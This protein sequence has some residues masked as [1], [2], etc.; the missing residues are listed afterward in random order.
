MRSIQQANQG[1]APIGIKQIDTQIQKVKSEL[2]IEQSQ[3]LERSMREA[4]INKDTNLVL[5]QRLE[6]LQEE[7]EKYKKQTDEILK[8]TEG[9]GIHR[10]SIHS[11]RSQ[12]IDN[13]KLT[14]DQI[15]QR[16]ILALELEMSQK[17]K[18][19][20]AEIE[21]LKMDIKQLTHDLNEAWNENDQKDK[22]I[23]QLQTQN[24]LLLK[25]KQELQKKLMEEKTIQKKQQSPQKIIEP[26]NN[27]INENSALIEGLK[28]Q[29]QELQ[30]EISEYDETINS[31]QQEIS[32]WKN[33]YSQ[34]Q[35]NKDEVDNYY[36]IAY[37]K[38]ESLLELKE[39]M[40]NQRKD[41]QNKINSLEGIIIVLKN[42]LDELENEKKRF[43]DQIDTI[44]KNNQDLRAENLK[45]FEQLASKP[46]EVNLNLQNDL[47]ELC[48]APSNGGEEFIQQF[49][50]LSD[51][52]SN[53]KSKYT[54]ALEQKQTLE[55]ENNRKAKENS[56]LNDAI[57][58][59]ENKVKSQEG[60]IQ[61]WI[62]KYNSKNT[63]LNAILEQEN[64]D[65]LKIEE[66]ELHIKDQEI[67]INDLEI[68]LKYSQKDSTPRNKENNTIKQRELEEKLKQANV[69]INDLKKEIQSLQQQQNNQ[70]EQNDQDLQQMIQDLEEQNEKLKLDN[71]KL[72]S[73]LHD[74]EKQISDQDQIIKQQKQKQEELEQKYKQIP[75][76]NPSESNQEQEALIERLIQNNE[77]LE[78]KNSQLMQELNLIKNKNSKNLRSKFILVGKLMQ[79][80]KLNSDLE[81]K[82]KKQ[83][84]IINEL[85][86][87][88]KNE[89]T[90]KEN[91]SDPIP[92]DNKPQIEQQAENEQDTHQNIKEELV[93][94]KQRNQKLLGKIF[95]ILTKQKQKDAIISQLEERIEKQKA[96][97]QEL[98]ENQ[99]NSEQQPKI[100]EEEQQ[101][102]EVETVHEQQ[103]QIQDNQQEQKNEILKLKT[104]NQKLLSKI[105]R[106]M[107]K[108]KIQEDEVQN[109]NER[110]KKQQAI[111]DAIT[112]EPKEQEE[113]QSEQEQL[114]ID[115]Q[116]N[117]KQI[118]LE[119]EN[120]DV[121]YDQLKIKNQNQRL[122]GKLFRTMFLLNKKN[123]EIESLLQRIQK[124]KAQ[125]EEL[126]NQIHE[127]SINTNQ[128]EE[129]EKEPNYNL[130]NNQAEQ[131]QQE[132]NSNEIEQQNDALRN[133][134]INKM[135]AKLFMIMSKF[136]KQNK[137]IENLNERLSKY[138]A[139]IES[140]SQENQQPQ[141]E[142]INIIDEK[143][144]NDKHSTDQQMELQNVN[145]QENVRLKNQN[146]KLL[147][148]LF[149]V[150]SGFTRKNNQIQLLEQ[151]LTKLQAII[152]TLTQEQAPNQEVQE[153]QEQSNFQNKEN[154]N[155]Q[156]N[157][158]S[159][160]Q[161]I[162]HQNEISIWKQKY[163]K[164]L[165]KLFRILSNQKKKDKELIQ[166]NER[167]N[168]QKAINDEL[169]EEK[170]QDAQIKLEPELNHQEI[171]LQAASEINPEKQPEIFNSNEFLKIKNQN[172]KALSKL[173]RLSFLLQKQN[174][175]NKQLND[176]L[177]KQNAIIEEFSKIQ[178][179]SHQLKLKNGKLLAKLFILTSNL[180]I[181]NKA[182]EELSRKLLQKNAQL[183]QLVESSN[184]EEKNSQMDLL[185]KQ[186][187][188]K[189]D[190]QNQNQNEN[191]KLE[192]QRLEIQNK[193]YLAKIFKLLCQ[194]FQKDRENDQLVRRLSKQKAI[195]QDLIDNQNYYEQQTDDGVENMEPQQVETGSVAQKDLQKL[196]K[197]NEKMLAKQFKLLFT[198]KKLEN[199]LENA[200]Q[201]L[202]KQKEI[203]LQSLKKIDEQDIDLKQLQEQI[204]V[205]KNELQQ[206]KDNLNPS[207][208]QK[209]K[210]DVKTN[211]DYYKNKYNNLL[212]EHLHLLNVGD[213]INEQEKQLRKEFRQQLEEE[214]LK[215][216]D[217]FNNLLNEHLKLQEE[218]EK[219]IDALNSV[220]KN[221]DL[222]VDKNELE[223][224]KNKFNSLLSEHLALEELNDGLN[225]KQDDIKKDHEKQLD[226]EIQK[227]KEKY[228][229]LLN[230]YLLL[231]M[232]RD[233]ILQEQSPKLEN[234]LDLDKDDDV[235]QKQSEI[236]NENKEKEQIHN[237]QNQEQVKSLLDQL[238]WLENQNSQLKQELENMKNLL[239]K[240]AQAEPQ[241]I[242][243]T[244]PTTEPLK[245]EPS[246]EEYYKNKYNNLLEE[247][248]HLLNVGDLINEQEKQ[249]RK[250][251]RQ[252]LEEEKLKAKDLFNNL[253]NEH[254]KLQEE[255]EKA[256]DAL[257]SVNKN[258]DLLVDKNE[259]ETIKNKFN[260]LLSEHL[261]LEE[262]NDGLNKKQ[263]DIKKDHEKQLDEEIQKQKEKYNKLLNQYLLLEMQRDGILQEQS[264]KLENQLDLDKDDDVIQKQSEIA[265]ENKEKEQI[266]NVQNQEQVKQLLDQL[267]WLENQ[268][269]QL[270]QELEAIKLNNNSRQ[271][272]EN[273]ETEE[274][275]PS[276][277][278]SNQEQIDK[279]TED[280]Y[281]NKYNN[282]LEEHLHL[283][284][285]GDLINEQEKQLR[286]EFRQQLE[287]EKLKAKDLFNNL[288]NEHL[289]LQEECERAIDALNSVN[290][291]QDLLVDKNELETIK[292]KFNSLLSEHLA[293]EELNDGLNKKQDDIKK[294]HEKQLDEEIQKQK[295]KYNK[296]LNQYLLL[297]MQRDGI[298]QEQSP[299]L[300]N[301]LDLDKDDDVIQKQSEIA[302]ENKEKDQMHNVQN[303]EQVKQLLDQL[304]QLENQNSQL[305]YELENM[306]N[307]LEKTAQAEPQQIVKTE[308]TIEPLK[309]EP[310]SEEYY[311]N[312]YNNLLE[313]HLHLLNVGDLIN[314][315][316]KQLRKEF[317]QQLEEEKL[318][319]KDLF[320]NLLNEHL[321]L[322]EECERAI[323]ALNSVNKNQ[324][325]LVDKNELET[326]KNKFNSLLSE[327]L[328]LE[329]LNDGLNKKQDDIKKDH[330][331]QL[332]EEIQ[333]QKEKYNKLLNQYLLLEMQR[334]GILQEQSPKLENQL[335][336]DK[337]D[338]VI[339]K[340]SEIA[341]ENKEKEQIHNVQNQEQVKQLLDQLNWLEN[342]NSQLKQELEAIKLNNNSRQLMENIETEEKE[343]S[344]QQSNQEQIDKSTEDYYKN[345]YNNL[346]E[347]HLHLLN[348]G[349]LINEQE[350][351]LRKEFR[352]QLEEEKLKAK[353][354]FNNLLNEHLKLQEECEK[355]IDALNS[356]NK[357]QDLLVDKNELE[358]IKNKFNSLLSE[359]LALEEL[360]DG[361]NKKQDDIKKDHE[362]QLDEEIQKQKEKYNKLLNQYLLLEMQ[363][364]G[365]LQEQSPKL[366]NQ[367]DLDK[368]DDVIQKQ[369]EIA[370]ENKE[371]EQIHNVQNQEQVKQL[372]DQLNWLENQNSQLKQELEAIKLNNNSR[373]L[374]ENIETEEKE[375]SKQQSNQEQI[376]KSTED[377]YKN[378]YN[379]LLEEH[380]HLL[381]VGDLINEQEKQLRKEFRQQ[382]EE[383]KLKAKDLF[384]NLLNEHLKLQEECEKA[385]DALNSVN[386]NQDLLVDKNELETIKNKFNSLL[387][388]H[389][390]LEELNDGLNKKQDD[391][392]KDH[393]K[394]L[395]E[396]IQKQKEK[397]NKLLNQYLLLEM[398]RDGILQEQSPKLENQLD[399]DKDDDVIQKQSEIANENKE[400]EQIHNV[401]NQEQVKQ[402]LDQLN[403]L[404]NQNSQLKQELEAIKLNN[405]SRQL[406]ENIETEEKEPSKQQSNQE[407]IDKSTED[408]YKNKY[409]NLLEE[410]LHLLNVG[411]LI[412]EQE[413]QLRKE[414]RQQL[415]EEKLKAKDLFNNL[416]NEHL[417]LQ[418]EC[419]KAI[420][421]LNSVNKNQDLLVDKN[422][423]ETIKNKFNSLLS[424]HLALEEL[425]D[426]LN[427]KQDDIKKDHEKQLD[428]E[429]QKQKEKYNKLLNQY[430]LLEM[431]RD[432]ILQE[433][434]PKLEN[435]L[436]LD[437]D[438][439]VIQKQSEIA[440]EN[441]EK[442]QIHNQQNQEQVKSLLDQLH[443]LENQNSQLKQELENMKN[444][445]EKTAQA[446]PQQ[447]VKTEPT[448]EPLKIEPSSEEYYKNKY[449]NLLEEHL[450]LL[451]VGD[452]IN[453]Q[454]KQLRKEFRQQL[455]EEK[456]KAKDLFNNLLNEHLKLQE[457]CEKAIDALNSVNKN[458][459]L[460]V[461]KN[462]LETI[463]NK[464]NSLLSEHLALEELNDGLNK[465]QDDIK[466]DHEKQLDEEIQKQKEKYNKLLNQYLLLEMQRDGILQEQSPKLENQLDLDKDDDVVEKKQKQGHNLNNDEQQITLFG[467]QGEEN[468]PQLEEIQNYKQQITELQSQL[469]LL[470]EEK[471]NLQKLNLQLADQLNK[472]QNQSNLKSSETLDKL[473]EK[474]DEQLNST[475]QQS[476][477]RFNKENEIFEK[478]GLELAQQRQELLAAQEQLSKQEI[479]IT[480]FEKDKEL[481][482]NE[483][484]QLKTQVDEL[485]SKLEN[486]EQKLNE[487]TAHFVQTMEQ[488]LKENQD[489]F[490]ENKQLV[491]L[492]Q[493]TQ[494]VIQI[495]KKLQH[496]QELKQS[497]K[498]SQDLCS[499]QENEKEII[500]LKHYIKTLEDN[501][502]QYSDGISV[503]N[504]KL[505][506]LFN[507]NS[508]LQTQIQQLNQQSQMN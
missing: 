67:K 266:H 289:K 131:P 280:Y 207:K 277:Q 253:L 47:I 368:D 250:E 66:L 435:Q 331:K 468:S 19:F 90:E 129:Q 314:E 341:N 360:N 345:K 326:I 117:N 88:Q 498:Q 236:A 492:N 79:I 198:I 208:D 478:Q 130:Q 146:N 388:E 181:Q 107:T 286:K 177:V 503:L 5:S 300:E 508:L 349:D 71:D 438:D 143:L 403:W 148:K 416:L 442:E 3:A 175:E 350:K 153:V 91:S 230:Q 233:G 238:H 231:E 448:T 384:N 39:E 86:E 144:E 480:K 488:L 437:K 42:N 340:Q 454:E 399:L 321:K 213:L 363:R 112:T 364:D 434:S 351:Q 338:D 134:K 406:M 458:Q 119:V 424:E 69:Q 361:L 465:K 135:A 216:K 344:K 270:K 353:D 20:L 89:N 421:A 218:C 372:L 299:K 202:Q 150:M 235:I 188:Q 46:L 190:L 245:I 199:Q 159:Q 365:I 229:K 415:E 26:Q 485:Q 1:Q 127:N 440:N 295:E 274:K 497:R 126:N 358:T 430:L 445:L 336:L 383:E 366:E 294:D 500:Q 425:N 56:L 297:E 167:L 375:P 82:L 268:N 394:Q 431:Q 356:V 370:N 259:L 75:K 77:Q 473:V 57:K 85:L 332:D 329:E 413:K 164:L 50:Q 193:K 49:N 223:T 157:S 417:K 343:P 215:A 315:Q 234:Q 304:N 494:P 98:I 369:S 376:D 220:N 132:F 301:Q 504:R 145:E 339:Q 210:Q 385:I 273:I 463:K 12:K 116:Q 162:K 272:M 80:E 95:R 6:K 436:D 142:N 137:L 84:G 140:Q 476:Q 410:H 461:D 72:L 182:N 278:Q 124:Q 474:K 422:E 225:K 452:L 373:Q 252:Q 254:L 174:K 81:D 433:Q 189:E 264:P 195:V 491:L 263:D 105:L 501:R 479:L 118:N 196:Q 240:T 323:D 316:E 180:N 419:E 205:L 312:K 283:L 73:Q 121:D 178:N 169:M 400:K 408:Y 249:L 37:D 194:M 94:Q 115:D 172:V 200:L 185:Q 265:N 489:D 197:A 447:I 499:T 322:Q 432:G 141:A 405:N 232:Q 397:Y 288:L 475:N 302:N 128:I 48:N 450:H 62:N 214:K 380:L 183:Q 237:Q 467:A 104:Q 21:N 184:E 495:L 4:K 156:P 74:A 149:R 52:F 201:R 33:K 257:N 502:Q 328:A 481:L 173:F 282:L 292:N 291:N 147:V 293:L 206:Q 409:N 10:S 396:E 151:R 64:N 483:C 255:C 441:K 155:I 15:K 83:K 108:L 348:V 477:E 374:M 411:D 362:K 407:Q 309:I 457:E 390:A 319:A 7:K 464:F 23:E 32:D 352:Q 211:Q 87:N 258:Q 113:E 420:D 275:E 35:K 139:I 305:K 507:K 493:A 423:L 11:N 303:Q 170:N 269:S 285:V 317:R 239:E 44:Q 176:R 482:E 506:E 428:E 381:N 311:K 40:E 444:L 472:I 41:D 18:Q 168:K 100:N 111:N 377:Y 243:K 17:E 25:E 54:E 222:L 471:D 186:P 241:Q 122:Q 392:K 158:E 160:E 393:E 51:D 34:L 179:S 401:Q 59:L 379:N 346:L 109:L 334:D 256:I 246:S 123:N 391:I 487:K 120:K 187:E 462:E 154:Q 29:I 470:N 324:D 70:V 308:P 133:Q 226:E 106:I 110:L 248:L 76:S 367:L 212:E 22:Q 330:E 31:H 335:D 101:Q 93:K 228:N 490:E 337:D 43:Q 260:S 271:L 114:I 453:E 9:P 244:E 68:A 402:L 469:L 267:N 449:N 192:N 163:N 371:K 333:K 138:K 204:Q 191:S 219:A 125:I 451:N 426:G 165:A 459:D 203:N 221:Q 97:N 456:L 382:L 262:L 357:N 446:E 387:S 306:K 209:E 298:L 427:K 404:E 92:Q 412:N 496:D 102:K 386:K 53:L 466:K 378:K 389:L 227:Q 327:H 217:L 281:K 28:K 505:I 443:W 60:E 58:K 61:D 414:F 152:D 342:Q 439:D 320:N 307:L 2:K 63:E 276:K 247:H 171:S 486:Q 78:V 455:E 65:K 14:Q 24:S 99:K 96:I 359:H 36:A 55:D 27:L 460:L 242:V 325:L 103:H 310:S 398:Q 261:A 161:Q 38:I 45:L 484:N 354:L 13:D 287:E 395:D 136:N 251:F 284:N 355:A 166:L 347:E 418:E 429:I 16:E 30:E 279:S 290:K 224:I 318:K 8:R 313:E 296:L